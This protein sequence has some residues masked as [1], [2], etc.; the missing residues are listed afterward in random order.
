M[1]AGARVEALVKRLVFVCGLALALASCAERATAPA[2]SG[3]EGVVLF[4]PLC[5]VE[6]IESP[7]PDRPV[8]ATVTIL[9]PSAMD[10]IRTIQSGSDGRFRVAL[11]PGSYV[12]TVR[13]PTLPSRVRGAPPRPVA[14][15]PVA[16]T[17]RP[18]EF[19][20]VTLKLDS[21][22]R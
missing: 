16:V 13:Q 8:E 5:P 12:L 19:A 2:D 15:A 3:V 1:A 21:G 4:G 20:Q 9:R 6:T 18:H 17:V 14:A 11:E 22:I 7:C 10:P